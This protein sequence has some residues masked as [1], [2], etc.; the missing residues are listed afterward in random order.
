MRETDTHVYFWG[1]FM[2]NFA[3]APF[4]IDRRVFPV[5]FTVGGEYVDFTTS[6]QFYMACKAAH[7]DD[8]SSFQLILEAPDAKSAKAIGRKVAGFDAAEWDRVST[9]TMYYAIYNK[10][11]QNHLFMEKLIATGSKV[12]VEASPVDRIW[13]VGLHEDDDAILDEKNWLGQN[14]LGLVLMQVRRDVP[15]TSS[16]EGIEPFFLYK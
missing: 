1:S 5:N 3:W 6:E 13:G 10:F 14:R 9:S 16:W 12:L 4:K 11:F 2:S 8:E 7:F 15:R